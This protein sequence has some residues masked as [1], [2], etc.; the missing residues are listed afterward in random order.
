MATGELFNGQAAFNIVDLSP[1]VISK[2][3]H[4]KF[5]TGTNWNGLACQLKCPRLQVE[6]AM[7]FGESALL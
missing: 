7:V 6:T 5:F 1:Q 4:I 2:R 3:G